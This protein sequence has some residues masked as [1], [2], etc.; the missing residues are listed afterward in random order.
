M[1]LAEL[2]VAAFKLDRSLVARV[3]ED[4]PARA[5]VDSLLALADNMGIDVVA[6]GVE[7]KA[8]GE[9]LEAAGCPLAQGYGYARPMLVDDLMDLV[10]EGDTRSEYSS[11]DV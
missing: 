2:P 4:S 3:V 6:E 1:Y 9:Y 10:A 7:S 11:A 5:L 8:Q